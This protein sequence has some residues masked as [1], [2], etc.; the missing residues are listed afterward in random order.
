MGVVAV[1]WSPIRTL[2]EVAGGHS[3]LPG[4][5]VV[6]VRAAFSFVVSTILV[7]SGATRRQLEQGF[8]QPGRDPPS[9]Q[10]FWRAW[11][12]RLRSAP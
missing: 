3:A 10:R 8:E 1:V 4:F 7:L 6:S 2:R 11:G 5:I 9:R 12:G